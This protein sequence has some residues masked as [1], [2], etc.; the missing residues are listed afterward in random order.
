MVATFFEYF[1]RSFS[2]KPLSEEKEASSFPH[3][4][5][6]N[7]ITLLFIYK[8][9]EQANDQKE[10]IKNLFNTSFIFSGG[11]KK[12]PS[13]TMKHVLAYISDRVEIGL[14]HY[15]NLGKPVEGHKNLESLFFRKGALVRQL[16]LNQISESLSILK[17][18]PNLNSLKIW[19]C[20]DEISLKILTDYECATTLQ[21]LKITS[22]LS[23][24]ESCLQSLIKL[25]ALKALKIRHAIVEI[26]LSRL[27]ALSLERL[28]LNLSIVDQRNLNGISS[29]TTLKQ[30][31]LGSVPSERFV[32][33]FPN[34]ELSH[35]KISLT[36]FQPGTVTV[37]RESLSLRVLDLG[38][39]NISHN[40]LKDLCSHPALEIIKLSK[41]PFVNPIIIEAIKA[42]NLRR[43][44]FLNC[45]HMH[46]NCFT[47]STFDYQEKKKGHL[48]IIRKKED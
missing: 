2:K 33:F 39:T 18:C 28:S 13:L 47:D 8:L 36:N 29:L 7:E 38:E 43:V 35:L 16:T 30:L 9:A 37:L 42:S 19:G 40:S 41:N 11:L 24:N 17:A 22:S 44:S 45:L 14:I 32:S 26:D 34:L 10:L 4:E 12:D 23:L 48:E 31:T 6:P 25:T 27:K 21:R 1:T 46:K 20:F 15:W 5:A 3:T